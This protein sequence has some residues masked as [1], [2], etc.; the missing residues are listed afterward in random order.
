MEH[1]GRIIPVTPVSLISHLFVA[2]P[3]RE[4]DEAELTRCAKELQDKLQS[5]GAHVYLPR[6]DPEYTVSVGLRMLTLRRLV[7]EDKGKFRAIREEMKV[8]R[9]YA[10]AI[11]HLTSA[12]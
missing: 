12:F 6:D 7:A 5:L 4:F 1:I 8:L 9:Y 2:H 3:E 11:E 10:N